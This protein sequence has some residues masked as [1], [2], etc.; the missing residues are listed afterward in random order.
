MVHEPYKSTKLFLAVLGDVTAAVLAYLLCFY[1]R[2]YF[3]LPY[4][5]GL[6]PF[7]RFQHLSHFWS[8]L[9]LSQFLFLYFA[10]FYDRL[11]NQPL[12]ET[13]MPILVGSGIQ[14]LFLAAC[15]SLFSPT[16]FPRTL[17][18]IFWVGNAL[19]LI[20]WR[21]L[22]CRFFSIR[23][24]LR[25][26]VLG[27]NETS[28]KLIRYLEGHPG[29]GLQI[30]GTVQ[31][32]DDLSFLSSQSTESSIATAGEFAGY[33]LLG[34]IRELPE[35]LQ[36]YQPEEVVLS[37]GKGWQEE[38][39]NSLSYPAR[40]S[41]RWSL[42]PNTY[43]IL[44][45]KPTHMQIQDIPL[46]EI[47]DDPNPPSRM[48]VKRCLDLFLS[49]L[50]LLV[51]SP[52]LLA[53]SFYLWIRTGRPLLYLQERVGK[54]GRLFRMIKFR[55]MVR[56]A[57]KE[58]GAMLSEWN[59]PRITP[60]GRW[61]RRSRL[62]EVPQLF[63]ILRGEMSFIG[64]RPERPVFVSEFCKTIPGYNERLRVKP[65]L[66]GL[67]QVNGYYDTD[68][69]QKLKYDIYY[70]HNFSLWLDFQ[71]LIDTLKIMLAGKGR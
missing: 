14:A 1:L 31:T 55:T 51:L 15:Y 34:T 59:D 17:F 53:I 33:P 48:F 58:S 28:E 30:L 7:S 56:D 65:G 20:L 46:L 8:V 18:P 49:I 37:T 71:I 22:L 25:L 6:M 3:S 41:I 66:T 42:L 39:L 27:C 47:A 67:A 54:D 24:K 70:I 35:I 36:Q 9:L 26:L 4:V 50:A 12:R 2:S 60:A 43:E 10:G 19:L 69:Y 13:I 21:S 38:I 11:W 68:A 63:N 29:L 40:R 44:I 23:Q 32:P 52:F 62:D 16:D 57:E 5:A 64:P 61:L 45:G